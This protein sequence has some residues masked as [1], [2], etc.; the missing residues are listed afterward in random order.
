MSQDSIPDLSLTVPLAAEAIRQAN[1]LVFACHVNP[2]GDALGS[3]IGLALALTPLQKKITLLSA[4]GVPEM[5]KFL[6][7][8]ELVQRG[9]DEAEFDLAIVLD[10]GD[11]SRVGASVLPV[12]E[13]ARKTID[14][15]HHVT[16]NSFGDIRV[17]NSKAASTSE[18]VY[19]L[20]LA[21]GLPIDKAIA[22][23]LFTG[24]ITDTGSF[25]FQNVTPNTFHVAASL[26]EHGAPPAYISENVFENRSFAATK[27]LGATLSTLTST[28]NGRVI[29]AHASLE[30]FV[31]LGATDEDTEGI[32]N[33]VRGVRDAEVGVFFREM[34]GG[35]VRISLRSRDTVN[36]AEIAAQFGGGGHKM[37]AGCS[38]ARP[39]AEAEKLVIDAILAV[40]PAVS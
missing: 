38:V 1:T 36:V 30:D 24:V 3:M 32:V 29:W 39:L 15:D 14:I 26:L 34:P 37:A 31:A 40:L 20:V 6:P 28:A 18:I 12:V 11:L 5:Y 10:S 7:G 4:D 17:L 13:R 33:Y 25:R 19:A 21:M 23:C 16:A 35:S 27:M 8:A 2:D 22:T 9:S